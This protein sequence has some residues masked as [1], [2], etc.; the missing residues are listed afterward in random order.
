MFDQVIEQYREY[1]KELYINHKPLQVD[2]YS[3]E[4]KFVDSDGEKLRM[5]CFNFKSESQDRC[6]ASF[7]CQC[8]ISD[9]VSR[10]VEPTARMNRMKPLIE[11]FHKLR[12]EEEKGK[13]PRIPQG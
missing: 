13:T 3:A 11:A 8:S 4:L 9:I 2:D 6:F 10:T 1:L 7:R 12:D 5:C